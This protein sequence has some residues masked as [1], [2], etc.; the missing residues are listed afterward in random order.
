MLVM[1]C[2]G[3][4][5]MA[6]RVQ[7]VR[8]DDELELTMAVDKTGYYV[9]EPVNVTLTVTNVSNQTITFEYAAWTF[10]FLVY[11]GSG[12]IFQWSSFRVF[13]MIIINW[14]LGPGD[15]LTRVLTWPQTCNVSDFSSFPVSPGD[16]YILGEVPSYG[17]QAGP[18]EVTVYEPPISLVPLKTVVGQGYS[19][20]LNVFIADLDE[21][22]EALDVTVSSNATTVGTE[23]GV[24]VSGTSA[25]QF[26]WN[27]TG[28]Q[29]GNYDLNVT[30]GSLTAEV[31][32]VLTVPGDINGDFKVDLS[33]LTLLAKAYNSKPG[34]ANWNPNADFRGD[35]MVWLA[36]LTIMAK[37]YDTGIP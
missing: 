31:S 13:P 10:D 2:V 29:L 8:A 27:T 22:S 5:A 24:N 4:L 7:P 16:Y 20:P 12:S 33:D 32:V 9:G 28:L 19:L 34:D 25:L 21:P 6:F 11:N 17:L 30:A 36:D 37:H 15:S 14:P 3:V 26:T 18:V 1:L 35:G 23:T